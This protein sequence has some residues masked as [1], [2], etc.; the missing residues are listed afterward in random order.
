M[1][2]LEE[3]DATRYVEALREQWLFVVV[4]VVLAVGSAFIFAKLS[5][6][7]YEARADIQVTPLSSNDESFVGFS[8]LRESTDPSRSVLTAARLVRTPQVAD[9][10]KARLRLKMD[11]RA[12][13]NSVAVNPIGQANILSIVAKAGNAS[14]A[15]RIANAFAG[16]FVRQRSRQ[17]QRQLIQRLDRL[18]GRLQATPRTPANEEEI[19]AIRGQLATLVPFVGESDPTLDLATRAEPPDAPA[20]PRP[21]LTIIVAL[22]A[23]LLLG[24][25]AALAREMFNPC[26]TR[27]DELLFVH[28]LP[29]LARVPRMRRKQVHDYLASRG[30][31]P[32]EA[33]DAYRLLRANLATAGP[34][35]NFPKTILLTS[36]IRGEGKTM[37]TV[38]LAITLANAGVKVIVVD[39]DL[40]HPMLATIFGV[41]LR[42]NGL[43]DVFLSEAPLE[44]TLVPAP[45]H[46]DMIRLVLASPD[47]AHLV[48]LLE[49]N[50]IVRGLERLKQ[51]ADVI[52]IDSPA[53]TEVADALSVA[54]AVEA[55]IIVTRLGH[56]R[57]EELS[58]LRGMLSYR[59]IAPTGLIVTTRR[60]RGSYYVTGKAERIVKPVPE[61][62]PARPL[63]ADAERG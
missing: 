46:G 44:H 37:S 57:R 62:A 45:G 60:R 35:G 2:A 17:F 32:G 19:T 59:G 20:W 22:F 58:E 13:L 30:E 52:L 28:R 33:W 5:S 54:D 63:K 42:G 48:D 10:V 47:D 16:E 15:A 55:V 39:G 38:N 12:L 31:L 18:K 25:G 43:A 3:R 51:R 53:L 24:V 6:K 8:L 40:R 1:S 56:T 41:A 29:V 36:A 61:P 21:V 26:I 27:E 50:R 14:E 9:G 49:P 4:I 34:S 23:S 7:R 11:R